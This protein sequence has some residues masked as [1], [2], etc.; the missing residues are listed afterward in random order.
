[1]SATHPA[2]GGGCRQQ[3]WATSKATYKT[4]QGCCQ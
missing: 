4:K 2:L 3:K 1:M